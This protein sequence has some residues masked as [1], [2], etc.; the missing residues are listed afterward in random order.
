MA[1]AP[2]TRSASGATR[3]AQFRIMSI[4]A[5]SESIMSLCAVRTR[6]TDTSAGTGPMTTEM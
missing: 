5:S 6:I 2:S 4:W 3:F 1:A